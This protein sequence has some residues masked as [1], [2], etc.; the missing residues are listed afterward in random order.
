MSELDV[1]AGFSLQL[2]R[3][4][5]SMAAEQEWRRRCAGAIQQV[6]IVS[7]AQTGDGTLDQ[8]DAMMAKTGYTWSLRRLTVYG[9][10]QGSVIVY[11]NA[12]GG[13]PLMPYPVAAVNTFSKGQVMLRPGERL[14][15]VGT[16]TAEDDTWQ[17][18][19]DADCFESW[20]L[21]YYLG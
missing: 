12:A 13:E 20:Y 3:I 21:P 4:A 11:K 16:G 6:C 14:V 1:I 9:F 8:P 19:A 2:G 15:A 10:T 7:P 5:D 17:L 18:W